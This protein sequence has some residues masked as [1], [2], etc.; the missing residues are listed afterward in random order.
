MYKDL[1]VTDTSMSSECDV[2]EDSD[3]VVTPNES[4]STTAS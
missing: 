1:A 4:A 3:C 2:G